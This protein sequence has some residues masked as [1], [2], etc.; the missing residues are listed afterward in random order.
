MR[1]FD[2]LT[3]R[4]LFKHRTFEPSN[5]QAFKQSNNTNKLLR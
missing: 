5:S 2:G 4:E 3:V 1:R